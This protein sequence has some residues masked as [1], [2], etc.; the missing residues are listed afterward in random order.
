MWFRL[1]RI[2]G[3][4]YQTWLSCCCCCCCSVLKLEISSSFGFCDEHGKKNSASSSGA[5]GITVQFHFPSVAKTLRTRPKFLAQRAAL[6][7]RRIGTNSTQNRCFPLVDEQTIENMARACTAQRQ[8][9]LVRNTT[10]QGKRSFYRAPLFRYTSSTT[11]IY[12]A[13]ATKPRSYS[14]RFLQT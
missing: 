3:A 11:S 7:E 2:V 5:P 4:T 14:Q 8:P 9:Q 12:Y 13:A 10:I 1:V 6:I